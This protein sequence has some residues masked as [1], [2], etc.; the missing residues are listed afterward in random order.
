MLED[1]L[2]TD[3][4]VGV[5]ARRRQRRGLRRSRA[6]HLDE[7]VYAAGR[8]RHDAGIAK[9]FGD[10]PR[11]ISV[12]RS[13]KSLVCAG[14][15]L[16]PGHEEHIAHLRQALDRLAIEQVGGDRLDATSR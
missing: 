15:E 9:C 3:T 13:G 14:A 7:G 12:H 8:E 5:L 1:A 2:A 10:Q 4:G 6:F 16:A 11:K